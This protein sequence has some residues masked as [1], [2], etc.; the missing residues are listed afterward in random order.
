MH[1]MGGKVYVH[2]VGT[3]YIAHQFA[4]EIQAFCVLLIDKVLDLRQIQAIVDPRND[5]F[6]YHRVCNEPGL[7]ILYKAL[8]QVQ[9]VEYI[10]HLHEHVKLI[11]RHDLAKLA[12]TGAFCQRLIVPGL[13]NGAQLGGGHV[14]NIGLVRGILEGIFIAADMVR[15]LNKVFGIGVDDALGGLG[16]A[17]VDHHIRRMGQDI[18]G[19][20]DYA[21]HSFSSHPILFFRRLSI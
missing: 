5:I 16:R 20:F 18:A 2:I 8:F 7:Y 21:I 12:I 19:A 6:R 15:Q 4:L 1:Y 10:T 14:A 17:I 11:L 9:Q 13:G 3:L